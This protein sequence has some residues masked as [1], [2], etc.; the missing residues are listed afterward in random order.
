M[1]IELNYTN[2][3]ICI[4]IKELSIEFEYHFSS[5]TPEGNKTERDLDELS[6][7]GIALETLGKE[8]Q[9]KATSLLN[10]AGGYD[11]KISLR[12]RW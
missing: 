5:I 10:R 9:V 7:I 2:Q 12:F 11:D 6:N 8:I 3:T 4:S 1:T